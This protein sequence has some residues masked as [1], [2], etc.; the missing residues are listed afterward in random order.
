MKQTDFVSELLKRLKDNDVKLTKDE[1]IIIITEFVSLIHDV[2][3]YKKEKVKINNFAVFELG[4]KAQRKL[5]N[6][7]LVE[8]GDIMRVR[9]SEKF[10]NKQS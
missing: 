8:Q 10:K 2:V 5:P 9:L 4:R 3:L 7:K 1:L 6:G